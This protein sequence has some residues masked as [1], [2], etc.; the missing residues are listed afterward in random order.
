MCLC[1][2]S[3]CICLSLFFNV[4]MSCQCHLCPCLYLNLY[5]ISSICMCACIILGRSTPGADVVL[6]A[7][8]QHADA[9]ANFVFVCICLV[10][11]CVCLDHF[12]KTYSWWDG[13]QAHAAG[14]W[15]KVRRALG[16]STVT[17]SPL[18]SSGLPSSSSS[19]ASP[20]SS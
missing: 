11:A 10:F 17:L 1:L 3:C 18:S 6:G 14:T 9:G 2:P 5:F 13:Q 15:G 4:L 19:P 8:G 12:R 16:W 7:D 20:A